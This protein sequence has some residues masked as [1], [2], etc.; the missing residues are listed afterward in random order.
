MSAV[1]AVGDET[2]GAVLAVDAVA[3]VGVTAADAAETAAAACD[4]GSAAVGASVAAELQI[5]PNDAASAAGQ[6]VSQFDCLSQVPASS[7]HAAA[8]A[9]VAAAAVAAAPSGVASG[10][11]QGLAVLSG[12][13]NDTDGAS[14]ALAAVS[15]KGFLPDAEQTGLQY[16]V[17]DPGADEAPPAGSAPEVL[18][19]D[20]DHLWTVRLGS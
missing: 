6:Q 1:G 9:L 16:A 12:V 5:F 19:E 11:V 4:A 7:G 10:A 18:E 17:D 13:A 14:A 3:T 15:C 2:V 20:S 8:A